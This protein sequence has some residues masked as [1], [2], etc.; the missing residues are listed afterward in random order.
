MARA[1]PVIMSG[2]TEWEVALQAVEWLRAW[3]PRAGDL[4]F[5]ESAVLTLVEM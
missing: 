1:W 3:T 2:M 5:V 4:A